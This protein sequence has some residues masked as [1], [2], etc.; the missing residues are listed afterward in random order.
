MAVGQFKIG[1]IIQARLGSTRLPNKVL[2]PLPVGS[3]RTIISE[4]IERVK[5]DK[6]FLRLFQEY[7]EFLISI[8]YPVYEHKFMVNYEK[9]G[10][11]NTYSVI[12]VFKKEEYLKNK[13]G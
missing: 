13:H 6:E 1:V 5:D 2:L 12:S 10:I 9:Y 4:I 11:I 8:D 7:V 3:E